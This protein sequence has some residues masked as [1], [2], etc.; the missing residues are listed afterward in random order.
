MTH[1]PIKVRDICILTKYGYTT[2]LTQKRHEPGRCS[3]S[4]LGLYSEGARLE[5]R[6]GHR[7]S[8]LRSSW[9]Y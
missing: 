3:S 7:L 2:I 6:P 9:F 1:A 8:R 5:S 4:V